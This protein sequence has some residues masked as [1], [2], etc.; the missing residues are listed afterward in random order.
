MRGR[1]TVVTT[2]SIFRGEN[3]D[4]EIGLFSFSNEYGSETWHNYV[5]K[6][7]FSSPLGNQW[8]IHCRAAFDEKESKIIYW[9]KREGKTCVSV[10]LFL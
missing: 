9:K 5:Q 7:D 6:Q 4:A 8:H 10:C 1:G 3:I 2:N